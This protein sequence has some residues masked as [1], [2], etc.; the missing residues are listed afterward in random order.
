LTYCPIKYYYL[1]LEN[2][3]YFLKMV[4]STKKGDYMK[5][6]FAVVAVLGIF[7]FVGCDNGNG[8][9]SGDKD[10]TGNITI[11]PTTAFTGEE[12]TANYSGGEAVSYQWNKDGT[13]IGGKT[14]Q[15]FTPTEAGSYTVTVSLTGYKGKTSTA[16]TVTATIDL[17]GDITITP[18]TDV[19]VN[20]ELTANYSGSETVNYQWNKDGT[21][22]DGKTENKFTPTEN[23]SYTVTVILAGYNSK[24]S[25]AITVTKRDL[26]GNISIRPELAKP[27]TILTAR[28]RSGTETVNYQWNK[29]GTAIDGE[30]DV[31]FTPDEIGSYTV[32]V[33]ATDY[34]S[35]TSTAVT[36][37]SPFQ[38][39]V[40]AITSWNHGG[41][42]SLTTAV[43]GSTVTLTGTVSDATRGLVLDIP[44]GVTVFWEA[45]LSSSSDDSMIHMWNSGNLGTLE[46]TGGSITCLNVPC[47]N[48]YEYNSPTIKISGGNISSNARG[49]RIGPNSEPTIIISGGTISGG[50]WA[51]GTYSISYDRGGGTITVSGSPDIIENGIYQYSS[52]AIGYYSDSITRAMFDGSWI[53]GENLFPKEE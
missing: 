1:I 22:I 6:F 24:T 14:A 50:N 5:R 7:G 35:K 25:T 45:N 28:Y 13:A 15:T 41:T 53:E 36:V 10:L 51:G 40:A 17:T 19:F 21:V 46:I 42:G 16:V 39:M 49:I 48:I 33:S 18:N 47:I 29:D 20:M 44:S 9:K 3:H 11:S 26:T 27:G 31:E 8:E 37:V 34:N 30:T 2:N 12:L 32:T 43:S 38:Y 23:G 52:T 4:L